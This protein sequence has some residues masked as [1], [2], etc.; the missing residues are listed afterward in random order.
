MWCDVSSNNSFNNYRLEIYSK[1]LF[2]FV[3]FTFIILKYLTFVIHLKSNIS[4]V[5]AKWHFNDTLVCIHATFFSL[6]TCS[7]RLR[8]EE[9]KS[10][11]LY[12]LPVYQQRLR[13]Q[14]VPTIN[15]IG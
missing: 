14:D 8:K 3:I 13:R 4:N 7:Y 10:S 15:L 5:E 9:N 1:Y 6:N 2:F 12:F 11:P